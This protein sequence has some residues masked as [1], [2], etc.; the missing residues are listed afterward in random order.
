MMRLAVFMALA[1]MVAS[2]AQAEP[3]AELPSAV[4]TF[5]RVCLSGGV[6]AAARPV[7]LASAGWTKDA[8]LSVSVDKLGISRSI[9][10]NYDFSKPEAAEQWSATVDNRPARVVLASFPVKRRYAH[11]CALVVDDVANAMPYADS[12]K[13]AFKTFGIGGKSVDLVHYFEFAG[14]IAPE[15]H[16]VRGEVFTRSLASGAKN[17]MHIYV[18]Y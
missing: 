8:S 17:S 4:A 5:E 3:V 14:K 9:N 16:P 12:L 7:A 11:L 2:S 1:G 18:A 10:K 13:V 6:D 15:R